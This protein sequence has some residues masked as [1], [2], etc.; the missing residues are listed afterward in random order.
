MFR[1]TIGLLLVVMVSV[2]AVADVWQMRQRDMNHT[3]RADYVVPAASLGSGFF[4]NIVW[5]TP[6][7]GSPGNLSA[8]TMSFFDGAGPGGADIVV[9]TYHWPK[10]VQGMDRHDGSVFWY[11]NPAGGETI[12][13]ITPA[14]TSDGGTIFVVNDATESTSWPNG[15][16]LMAFST[17]AGPLAGYWHNGSS[18]DPYHMEMD[19]PTV[20]PYD[21][22]FLHNWN[23]RPYGAADFG[24]Y[25]DETWTSDFGDTMIHC[26]P[27][28]YDYEGILLVV[29]AGRNGDLYAWDDTGYLIWSAYVGVTMD[30]TATIDPATGNIY[31]PAGDNS[32][33][34][35]GSDILGN[36]LWTDTYGDPSYALRVYDHAGGNSQRAQAGGCLSADGAT[37]YFQTNSNAGDGVLYAVNT[38]D[39]SLKWTY[40]T[41]ST[42]WEMIS[43]SP[44]VTTNGVIVV[45]TNDG[46]TY[47]A[48]HDAA[49]GPVLLDT[50]AVDGDGQ[51]SASATISS[52]G[53]MYLPLRTV[54]VAGNGDGQTPDYLVHNL[55][56]A[57]DLSGQQSQ[58]LYPPSNQYAVAG[59]QMVKL[60]F[61]PITDPQGRFDHYAVYRDTMPFGS[62]DGMT[63]I[64]TITS[65]T[66]DSYTDTTAVNGMSY[67]YAVTTVDN[68]G[69]QVTDISS[70]GPRT[71]RDETD[72]QVVSIARTPWYPRYCVDYTVHTITEPTGYGPYLCSAATGLC[73]G[74]TAGTQHLPQVG[75]TVTYTATVRNRGTNTVARTVTAT[76]KLDGSVVAQSAMPLNL[77]PGDTATT[78]WQFTYDDQPHEL[79]FEID[80]VDARPENNS[81]VSDTMAVG[82]LTYIDVS[83]VETFREA[84][85]PQYPDARTDDVIDWLNYHMQRFNQM[86]AD[87]SC[88]K[89]VHF[90][91]LEVIDDTDDDPSVDT[92]NF[93]IFPFRYHAGDDDPRTSGYYHADEDIDYG[94]IHEQGHQLGLIDLYRLDLPAGNNDVSGLAYYGAPACVMHGVSPFISEHSA[95]AM[96]HWLHVAH[97]YYGQYLYCLPATTTMRFVSS[98]DGSPLANATVQVYQM[99]EQTNGQV[100]IT[101]QVKAQGTTDTNG[102]F[103]L[104]NVPINPGLVPTTYAGDTLSD[105]PFGYVHVVGTNGVLHFK[106]TY[107]D[108]VAYAWLDIT[109]CNLAYWDGQTD[110]A[111]FERAVPLG[112]PVSYLPPPELTEI[113]AAQWNAWADGSGTGATYA[114]DDYT[115]TVSGQSSLKFVTDGGFDTAV[116]FPGSAQ[117]RWNLTTATTMT[118]AFKTFNTNFSFQNGSPWIRLYDTD[119][120]YI[121]YQYYQNGYLHELL[122]DANG[123]WVFSNVP[124]DAGPAVNNGWRGTTHGTVAMNSIA[125]I[126]IHADTW[127]NG[128]TMWVDQLRFDLPAAMWCDFN[129]DGVVNAADLAVMIDNWMITGTWMQTGQT[130]LDQDGTVESDDL[131]QFRVQWL[132]AT[133]W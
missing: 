82:F 91:V 19:S 127:G 13:R 32:I 60:G 99:T 8:T 132:Q 59:N 64:G 125:S 122:N 57:F 116:S 104:P 61:T 12:G 123:S 79:T 26:D 86:L 119:G 18:Y 131:D 115:D 68:T 130:D 129:R 33:Y 55:Y 83:F 5:Q 17:T 20:G 85:S 81:L 52:D 65:V 67:Y 30:A 133:S 58:P 97:G 37:Y 39:G 48:I 87:A 10:G 53:M 71:P 43:S 124:L 77:A 16:P 105:N 56:T 89:R 47:L 3:G 7:P 27:T 94:L 121:E 23:G 93:A 112:G 109:E 54:R 126:E 78:Q 49:G 100:R 51:A 22:V 96:D 74:Q 73:G 118:V 2:P 63:P 25:L 35:V 69:A 24:G 36:P 120:D 80:I 42:G 114:E 9:G 11:G 62:V 106:I 29:G 88:E 128:F 103:T 14:F 92:I 117:A 111:V 38:A 101:N 70:V 50:F 1:C 41:G 75:Q 76:W 98:R 31:L 46:D 90:D 66:A 110:E 28:L 44:V 107:D 21:Q 102:Q 15:H 84:W 40:P 108:S 113:N 34:V 95:R 4:D 72:V 45:G 6:T